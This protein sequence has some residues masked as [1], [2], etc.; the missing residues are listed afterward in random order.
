MAFTR[1]SIMMSYLETMSA[2]IKQLIGSHEN[3]AER[4]T[5]NI[6]FFEFISSYFKYGPIPAETT[7]T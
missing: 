2:V 6:S 1:N 5:T 7:E 4:K 3:R